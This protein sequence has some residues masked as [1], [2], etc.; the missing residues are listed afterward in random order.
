MKRLMEHDNA[1]AMWIC[2]SSLEMLDC[3]KEAIVLHKKIISKG[4]D[5]ISVYGGRRWARMLVNDCRCCVGMCYY[6]LFKDAL[7]IK[8]LSKHLKNRRQNQVTV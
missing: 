6:V 7:A 8:W 2:A 4:V 3:N 1:M 5:K